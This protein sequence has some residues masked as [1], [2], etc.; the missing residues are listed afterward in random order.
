MISLKSKKKNPGDV[1]VS[2]SPYPWGLSLTLENETINK[3]GL[4][5]DAL[6]VGKE[7]LVMGYAKVENKR[8]H[9]DG[10][11]KNQSISLQITHMEKPVPKDRMKAGANLLKRM[12]KG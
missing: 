7:V 10:K 3:L 12:R 6:E 4:N 2:S 9:D 1:E 5:F 11:T 8:E